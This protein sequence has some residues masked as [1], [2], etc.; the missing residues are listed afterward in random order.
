ME[1]KDLQK[2]PIFAIQQPEHLLEKCQPR[3]FASHRSDT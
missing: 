2:N 3:S 1:N